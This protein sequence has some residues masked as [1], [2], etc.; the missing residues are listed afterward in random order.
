MHS[1]RWA[2]HQAEHYDEVAAIALLREHKILLDLKVATHNDTRRAMSKF[3]RSL[4][5]DRAVCGVLA[6]PPLGRKVSRAAWVGNHA[7]ERKDSLAGPQNT[8]E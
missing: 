7:P 8:Q 6:M 3:V 2:G 5:D 4:K 1:L